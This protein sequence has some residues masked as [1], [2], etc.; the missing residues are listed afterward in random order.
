M[1]HGIEISRLTKEHEKTRE[2]KLTGL[3]QNDTSW[4]HAGTVI[5]GE[6]S[7]RDNAQFMGPDAMSTGADE[8]TG[9]AGVGGSY[10]RSNGQSTFE[11]KGTYIDMDMKTG[12]KY[13][14]SGGTQIGGPVQFYEG[15]GKFLP[16]GR[17]LGKEGGPGGH[18]RRQGQAFRPEGR[19]RHLCGEV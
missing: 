13:E 16:A 17:R 8:Y 3:S 11:G 18:S 9:D 15:Q 5:A 14:F 7:I 19:P 12:A 6:V 2:G 1:P 10:F 4:V